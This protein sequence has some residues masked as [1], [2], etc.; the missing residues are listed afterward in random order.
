MRPKV[1][2]RIAAILMLLHT[3]GHSLG[4]LSWKQAPNAAVAQVISG[5]ENN[6]FG[7]MGRNASIAL[8]Y[9]GYGIS[10]IFVLL[11]ISAQLW[12]LSADDGHKDSAKM[13]ISLT[14]FLLALSVT[15][16]IYFFTFAAAVSFISGICTLLALSA[17][18]KQNRLRT[19]NS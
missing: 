19:I 8:F 18:V 17:G 6:H 3:V 1:L 10:M 4:A 7:F 16:Y 13:L 12:L 2:I 15:E 14:V 9:N 11:L 5:M